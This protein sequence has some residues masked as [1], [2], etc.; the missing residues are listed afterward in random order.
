MPV[1]RTQVRPAM[2]VGCS[3]EHQFDT[4]ST[5]RT[6]SDKPV[7]AGRAAAGHAKPSSVGRASTCQDVP[8]Q[9]GGSAQLVD[10][11]QVA[12]GIAEGAVANP[13]RLLGGFLDDFGAAGLQ[14]REG[15]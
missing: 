11:D 5:V 3:I 2:E 9:P 12:G 6:S 14:P 15:A 10:A 4:P 7:G 8:G 13:V 1:I